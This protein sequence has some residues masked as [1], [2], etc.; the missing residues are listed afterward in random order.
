MTM[1]NGVIDAG[2]NF[3][4]LLSGSG[5]ASMKVL[6]AKSFQMTP[7]DMTAAFGPPSNASTML[8]EMSVTTG[9]IVANFNKILTLPFIKYVP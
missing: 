8:P 6:A 7:G 2:T 3:I 1:W 5:V 9:Q 4:N